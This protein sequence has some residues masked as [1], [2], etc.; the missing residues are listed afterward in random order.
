MATRLL[1]A[2]DLGWGL[3]Q[4]S[5]SRGAER[6]VSDI[7]SPVECFLSSHRRKPRVA[8]GD[9]GREV[10]APALGIEGVK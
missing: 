1:L 4:T 5:S 10:C 2:D 7:D 9:S 6:R 8:V 3:R